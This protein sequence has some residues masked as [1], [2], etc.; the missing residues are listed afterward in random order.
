MNKQNH[1]ELYDKRCGITRDETGRAVEIEPVD[2]WWNRGVSEDMAIYKI[3]GEL[4][5]AYGWNGEC[6]TESFRVIDR[7]TAA[8]EKKHTLRPIYRFQDEGR[9]PDEDNDD[10]FEIIGFEL[11]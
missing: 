2:Y 8:D 3:G 1:D 7:L 10:D 4:Y 9:E 11:N 6:Y 5:C